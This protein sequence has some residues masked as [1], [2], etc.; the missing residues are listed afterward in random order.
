MEFLEKAK[1]RLE[2]WIAHNEQHY[3]EYEAFANQ[4]EQAGKGES[5]RCVRDMM[6]LVFKSNDCL[7]NALDALE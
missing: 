4:L 2:H 5:A 6:E 7:R 1:I 3:E